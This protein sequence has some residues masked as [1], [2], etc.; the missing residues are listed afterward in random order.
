MARYK[1]TYV[2]PWHAEW[3]ARVES[4]DVRL[5]RVSAL[6]R[7]T[8]SVRPAILQGASGFERGYVDIVAAAMLARRGAPVL[9]AEATWQPGSRALD[10]LLKAPAPVGFDGDPRHGRR[11]GRRAIRIVDRAN[12][13]YAV[14]SRDEL[15]TFPRVWGVDPT[16]VHFLPFCAT[17]SSLEHE[18]T[19]HGVLASGNSLRDYRALIEAAPKIR[20]DVMLATKLPLPTIT[21]ANIEAGFLPPAAHDARARSAAVVV[22]PLLANTERSAGQ[23]TYLNAMGRGKPVVVTDAPGVRDYIAH[24]E[25]GL[26]VS[27]EPEALGDAVNR[28]LTDRRLA[29]RLGDAARAEVHSR[30]GLSAYVRRLLE[31]ADRVL[32]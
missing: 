13:H 5:G 16:R 1:S 27:N 21:A 30:F 23:Q 32:H 25:T 22:V 19:G 17:A 12:V 10:R 3:C 26:I 9:L 11:L 15:I 4:V 29:Q 6:A 2:F 18:P 7:L 14:L 20:A 31:L 8:R 28:L 24:G